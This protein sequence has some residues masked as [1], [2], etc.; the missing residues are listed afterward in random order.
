[1]TKKNSCYQKQVLPKRPRDCAQIVSEQKKMD[2]TELMPR[3]IMQKRAGAKK[4]QI[5]L[6]SW[7]EKYEYLQKVDKRNIISAKSWCARCPKDTKG[8]Q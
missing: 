2:F 1:M 3:N 7:Q 4:K 6:K 8:W 5:C